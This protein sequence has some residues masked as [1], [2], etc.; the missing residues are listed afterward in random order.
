MLCPTPPGPRILSF[1][2]H[3]ITDAMG[4]MRYDWDDGRATASST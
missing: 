2:S 1:A 3:L 4:A